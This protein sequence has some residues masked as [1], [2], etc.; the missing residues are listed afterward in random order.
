[1]PRHAAH[2]CCSSHNH[3]DLPLIGARVDARGDVISV[4]SDG[5]PLVGMGVRAEGGLHSERDSVLLAIR[6]DRIEREC[7]VR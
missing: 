4:P 7:A 3:H 6:E 5:R 2:G 1:M